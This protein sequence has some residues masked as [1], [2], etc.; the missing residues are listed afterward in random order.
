MSKITNILSKLKNIYIAFFALILFCLSIMNILKIH[1]KVYCIAGVVY[2]IGLIFL[3]F[4]A[5][6]I[7]NR[8][9]F[10]VGI[11]FISFLTRLIWILVANTEPVSDFHLIN[12][13]AKLI[14]EGSFS[15]LKQINYFNMW[16][17][18][19][20]FSSYC[21]FLYS[22]FSVNVFI[23]KLFNV[24]FSTG[25]VLLIYFI[26]R[27]TFNE[28]A[29]RISSLLY[30]IYIQ[31]IIFNSLLTNQVISLFFIY[32]GL[33][34]I[35]YKPNITGYILSGISMA[36]GHIFRPEGSFMLY[37][38]VFS[39]LAYNGFSLIKNKRSFKDIKMKSLVPILSKIAI[40]IICFN[41]F[42]QLFGYSLRAVGIT[43]YEYKNRNTYWKF[44]LGLNASTNGGYSNEDAKLLD[45]YPI[46]DLLYEKEM[47]LIK[48]RL[49]NK[50]QLVKLMCRKF[51]LM[52][53]DNDSSIQFISPGTGFND[54]ELNYIVRLEKIQ[55]TLIIILSFLSILFVL[56]DKKKYNLSIYIL[57][58]LVS[59]NWFVYL[60]IEIQTRYRYFIMP[61]L[62]I[63]AGFGFYRICCFESR[64]Q[65]HLDKE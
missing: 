50:K 7:K 17:Y 65:M 48:E 44:V 19:L 58:L 6:K 13:A 46:G 14:L 3:C 32:L 39:I 55:Y 51:S 2:V 28:K 35:L 26:S 47:E 54:R 41:M 43:D 42:V 61:C 21:A 59:A 10:L 62:F 29:A 45:E 49:S 34:I 57:I 9:L 1:S 37:I 4:L 16:V 25:C 40:L 56:A 52:W 36:V 8:A 31:S 22:A 18:Q 23:V 15:E 24:F 64:D 63:L 20:G 12:H 53:S 38:V 30:C 33:A 5:V 60:L 27:K 11:T